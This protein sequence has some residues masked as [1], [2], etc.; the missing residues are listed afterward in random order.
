MNRAMFLKLVK[1]LRTV[2]DDLQTIVDDVS[3]DSPDSA[4]QDGNKATKL[5]KE[6]EK[7][8]RLEDV[9]AV[10][11]A[12]SREGYGE[13]VR[14]LISR[15]GADKLSKVDPSH[16]AEILKEAEVFGNAT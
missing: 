3:N 9:R 5:E 10:L 11:A 14:D 16:Y 2:A 6:P 13:N 12:K 7:T 15:F 8:I 1:D 4:I